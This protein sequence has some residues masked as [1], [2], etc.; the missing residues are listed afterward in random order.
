M[1]PGEA[2]ATARGV[3]AHRLRFPRVDASY[4][5]ADAD[6]QL[7]RD[8]ADGF[9]VS[10]SH[11]A[12]YLRARTAFFDRAVVDAIAGGMPQI[13]AVGAG[14]DGRS[15]RYAK[16]G[17]HW[18]ELDHPET[19]ADKRARLERL[20]IAS[21]HIGFAPADFT[22]DD[23]GAALRSTGHDPTRPSLFCCEGVAG[24][25]AADV[26]RALFRTLA[27][28]AAAG[29]QLA[30]TLPVEPDTEAEHDERARLNA[31]V[32]GLGEPL[33]TTIPRAELHRV[34]ASWG[35]RIERATDPAGVDIMR[36]A[37]TSAFVVATPM[38]HT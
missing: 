34:L 28:H 19:Q 13:V 27:A 5:F 26:L 15:L 21:G 10:D 33:H 16:P 23:V 1:R 4:G 38:V 36:T 32:S 35:W 29:S 6:Q 12:P 20:H 14:Y 30:A 31:R 8:V 11:L 17:V 7:Q 2:S 37:R 24:Y 18:F 25:L 3:A 22:S 9:D